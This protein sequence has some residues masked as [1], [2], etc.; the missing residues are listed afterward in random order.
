MDRQAQQIVLDNIRGQVANRWRDMVAEL[1]RHPEH[2]LGTFLNE[3]GVELSDVLKAGSKSWTTLQRD[4]RVIY[5]ERRLA[6][7]DC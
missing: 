3:S 4:A 5:G 1:R 7:S 2:D 6:R